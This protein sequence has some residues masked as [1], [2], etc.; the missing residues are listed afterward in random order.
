ME[1]ARKM[2]LTKRFSVGGA[3][4]GKDSGSN[5]HERQR[6]CQVGRFDA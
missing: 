6:A 5:A 4:K 1:T 2:R 3:V